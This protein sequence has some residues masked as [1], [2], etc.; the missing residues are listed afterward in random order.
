MSR[1]RL[2]T[3]TAQDKRKIHDLS[4]SQIE[5]HHS[6][7]DKEKVYGLTLEVLL[8]EEEGSYHKADYDTAAA[9]HA[10]HADQGSGL[11]QRAEIDIVGNAEENAYQ[12]DAP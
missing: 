6:Q 4:R 10:D 3:L 8:V 7:E 9:H 5:E 11:V 12:G 2:Y 1:W